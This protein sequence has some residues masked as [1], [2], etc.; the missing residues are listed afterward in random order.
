MVFSS[1]PKDANVYAPLA[2]DEPADPFIAG[3][4]ESAAEFDIRSTALRPPMYYN[5]GRFS[6]P[7]SVDSLEFEK[8]RDEEN[9]GSALEKKGLVVGRPKTSP[10]LKVL[11][12]CLLGLTS[13][14]IVF[15]V[16]AHWYSS[17]STAHRGSGNKHITMDHIFN[18]T[19]SVEKT[20]LSWVPEA[21]DG[22]YSVEQEGSIFLVDLETGTNRTLMN[23]E[24]AKDAAG[25]T[26][27]WSSWSLSADMSY[28][29]LKTDHLKQWRHSSFGNY[30]VHDLTTHATFPLAPPTTPPTISHVAWSPTG[31]A[32]A[33]VSGNDIY[34]VPSPRHTSTPIRVTTTGTESLFN[35]VPDWVYEEEV[36]ASD[37]TL[38]WAPDSQHLAF[39]TLDESAVDTF[40]YPVYNPSTDPDA[41]YPYT[42]EVKMKYPKPG[43][44]NPLVSVGIYKLPSASALIAAPFPAPDVL[45]LTWA[46]QLDPNDRIISEVAW[47][48]NS[49]M[50]LKEVERSAGNGNVVFFDFLSLRE[51]EEGRGRVV[52]KLGREGE[53]GDDGWI[54][55]EQR[56]YPLP[57]LTSSQ[58]SSYL[59]IVPTSEGY[60]HIAL[61]SPADSGTPRWLTSGEWEVTDN[62]LGV[63]RDKG[64]VYFTAAAPSSI[65]RNIYRVPLPQDMQ[66]LAGIPSV[67]P[68]ALT[69]DSRQS[70]YSAS[71]SPSAGYYVL[72]YDGPDV[73][74][75]KVVQ[76]GNDTFQ[77]FLTDNARLNQTS[78]E[79]QS[80]DIYR[81]TIDSDGYELNV[82]ELR[83]PNMDESGQTKYPVLFHVYGGPSSQQV[84]TRFVRDWHH[85]LACSLEYLI[86]VVDGRG[87][88]FKGR[89][90]R[91]PVR[92]TLGVYETLDQ[93]NA[94]RIWAA[95]DYVDTKRIG[96]WGW[97]YGGF[98]TSK[99][100]EA[101]VGV[102]TLGMAVAPVT[103]WR[104]YDSVYTERYMGLPQ[105]NPDGYLN[106][107]ITNVAGFANANYLLAHGSGDDNVHFLNSAHLLDML[108]A[109]K[110]RGFQFRMFTDSDH[111]IRMRG[112]YRELH[113]WM[114]AFLVEKWGT[115]GAAQTGW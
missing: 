109:A 46:A 78:S 12:A 43:Y 105:Q 63:D 73:P 60:N 111:G 86:V 6:P 2:H 95:K 92:G 29:L 71:F 107:S 89:K 11:V 53:Q 25:N 4:P 19:F 83:P 28:I 104:L 93:I 80:P 3:D 70:W 114:T 27:K 45:N 52:R 64:L 44:A 58:P 41:V 101:D 30:Y 91:N 113:E 79:F 68:T 20:S 110:I 49:S 59:D 51:A 8:H 55:S 36:F 33:Y 48:G 84:H 102:H 99:V 65:E 50:I 75:Q 54:D 10:A 69:D 40:T 31:A 14:A 87:T 90:L 18:G 42:K 88:G 16:S 67:K 35:G 97:S 76:V 98:M 103:S 22:I 96:I 7:S 37:F 106:A 66:D 1:R 85:Y 56:I 62:I 38:W 5:E 15:G 21:G 9:L 112:A 47:V 108:T 72:N 23:S 115:G 57:Q 77:H 13:A 82:M 26:L 39:L 61:F 94:A 100:I 34:V 74:W 17:T 24:D 32:I 81:S